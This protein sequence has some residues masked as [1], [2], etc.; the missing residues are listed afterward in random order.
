[1]VYTLQCTSILKSKEFHTICKSVYLT[2][3]PCSFQSSHAG[4]EFVKFVQSG[5]E[6]TQK[7]SEIIKTFEETKWENWEF[8]F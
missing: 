4:W 1:M 7:M 8:C 6:S 5:S 2:C 3:M